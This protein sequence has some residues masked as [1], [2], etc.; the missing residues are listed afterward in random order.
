MAHAALTGAEVAFP[1]PPHPEGTAA[2][3]AGGNFP[4]IVTLCN[5]SA[6][7]SE[8]ALLTD[9]LPTL[10]WSVW[11]VLVWR[12]SCDGRGDGGAGLP[13]AHELQYAPASALRRVLRWVGHGSDL[14]EEWEFHSRPACRVARANCCSYGCKAILGIPEETFKAE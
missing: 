4:H 7:L 6:G 5:A 3:P 1:E 11:R 12:S 14:E 10:V 8:Q 2:G 9:V 13:A